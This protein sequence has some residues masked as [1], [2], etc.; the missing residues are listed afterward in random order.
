MLQVSCSLHDGQMGPVKVQLV[1]N[2]SS[3]KALRNFLGTF[4]TLTNVSFFWSLAEDKAKNDLMWRFVK[5]SVT[6]P[7]VHCGGS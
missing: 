6:R 2:V 5:Y 7:S 1:T 3:C 4:T